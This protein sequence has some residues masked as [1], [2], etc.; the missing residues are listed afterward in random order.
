M[1]ADAEKYKLED[2]EVKKRV[3]AKNV[4]ENYMFQMKSTLGEP[5]L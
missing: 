4:F 5:K 2:E 1:L 3:E